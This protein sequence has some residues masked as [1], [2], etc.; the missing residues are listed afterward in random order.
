MDKKRKN[1]IFTIDNL[2]SATR[3]SNYIRNDPIIDYFDIV[4]KNGYNISNDTLTIEKKEEID[5]IDEP[6]NKKRKT[7]FDYIAEQGYIFEE[8]IINKIKKMMCEKNIEEKLITIEKDD[9]INIHY[10]KTKDI[11]EEYKYYVILG[12]ILI[13]K[14]NMTFG[15]PDMI[16]LGKWINTFINKPPKNINNDLYYIID[17]KSSTINLINAGKYVS[18]N[19]L[20]EGYKTQIWVYKEALNQI[21]KCETEYGFILG[22]KYRYVENKKEIYIKNSFHMLGFIDY[23]FEKN[24]GNNIKWKIGKA[25]KWNVELRKNWK[26]YKLYPIT[27]KIMPNMKNSFDKNYKKIKKNIAFKN[28]EITLLWNCGI[29]QRNNA[30][31]HKINKYTDKKLEPQKMGFIKNS[32]KYNILNKMLLTT[33]NNKLIYINKKNN[34]NK[35][36]L[37]LEN[38]FFVDFETYT[39][40]FDEFLIYNNDLNELYETQSIYMIGIGYIKNKEYNFKC[41]IIKYKNS[42][43]IYENIIKKFNCTK[44]NVI[45]VS[46]EK[47]LIETFINYVYSFK[48]INEPKYRFINKTRLIHWSKAEPSLF[49][50][51]LIKYNINTLNNTLPWFDLME[52][53]K[54]PSYPILIKNCFSFSLKDIAKT[55]HSYKMINLEWSDLDDGLLSTFIAKD[56]YKNIK[57]DLN[58]NVNMQDIIEYNYIDCKALYL[59]LMYIRN[60]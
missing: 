8:N 36:Q 60:C 56:I 38:E 26:K 46:N 14:K 10:K 18:C 11:I 23:K 7:S 1:D 13:N 52:I 48:K 47:A 30:L 15:Y 58:N 51:K 6:K 43:T 34:H 35:W 44:E 2:V 42:E 55:M 32:K 9:N 59:I 25:I 53:F 4:K 20:I 29:V 39:P 41:F 50:K 5:E 24:K 49:L 28:K 12:G 33:Q 3:L 37:K 45:Q 57:T 19:N 27:K 16:V 17:I 21:Q 31:K 22:K 54:E 40:Y